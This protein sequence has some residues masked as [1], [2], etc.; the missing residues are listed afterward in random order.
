M[1]LDFW[2]QREP[3]DRRQSV[4]E[5]CPW[6]VGGRG[7]G[8]VPQPRWL[9]E[10][11]EEEAEEMVQPGTVVHFA[12]GTAEDT[13]KKKVFWWHIDVGQDLDEWGKG[14]KH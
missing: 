12:E 3:S 13:M 5:K 11:L 1:H 7:W 9:D 14:L 6:D 10:L 2:R 8:A 4:E